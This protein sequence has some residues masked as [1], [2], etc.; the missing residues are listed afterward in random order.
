MVACGGGEGERW[1]DSAAAALRREAVAAATWGFQGVR[2]ALFKR[3]GLGLGR[4]PGRRRRLARV[5]A[6]LGHDGGGGGAARAGLARLGLRP[7]RALTFFLKHISPK[8]F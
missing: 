8:K 3:G 7:S 6:G 1:R 2:A 5:P 4:S